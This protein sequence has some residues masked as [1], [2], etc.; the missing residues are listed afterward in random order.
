[1][2]KRRATSGGF[3]FCF[4]FDVGL[5]GETAN[6]TYVLYPSILDET[7][8]HPTR[9]SK[10][11]SLVA[12][13]QGDRPQVNHH[14]P[15]IHHRFEPQL[16]LQT[17]RAAARRILAGIRPEMNA[18]EAVL[19]EHAELFACFAELGAHLRHETFRGF[20]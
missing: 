10:N 17:V 6:P 13:Y 12:G 19:E 16:S 5:R 9:L 3:I 1:M 14:L 8:S 7:T 20:L 18:I 2:Q 11:D 15:Q 4:A